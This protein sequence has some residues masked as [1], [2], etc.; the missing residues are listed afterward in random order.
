MQQHVYACMIVTSLS[1]YMSLHNDFKHSFVFYPL[2]TF[3][4]R[5][6]RE[7][8]QQH[9]ALGVE[10]NGRGLSTGQNNNR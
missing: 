3:Q 4:R 6:T 10:I 1:H 5:K 7:R 8:V 2:N 9:Q